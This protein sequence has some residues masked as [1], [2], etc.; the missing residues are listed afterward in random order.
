[1]AVEKKEGWWTKRGI[2][3][4]WIGI[5]LFTSYCLNS[6]SLIFACERKVS[7]SGCEGREGAD[8]FEGLVKRVPTNHDYAFIN[9]QVV[10]EL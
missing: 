9:V 1:M 7:Q 2:C 10:G 6:S 4:P 8:G 3:G 5:H